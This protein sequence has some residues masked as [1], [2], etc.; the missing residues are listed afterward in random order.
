MLKIHPSE[1]YGQALVTENATATLSSVEATDNTIQHILESSLTEPPALGDGCNNV[2]PSFPNDDLPQS[3]EASSQGGVIV[4]LPEEETA[5]L[6]ASPEAQFDLVLDLAARGWRLHPIQA[7]GKAPLLSGWPSKASAEKETIQSWVAKYPHCNW[8][9]A[10][11]A[12]SNVFVLDVDNKGGKKG[13]ESLAALEEQYG[14]LP[15]T[16]VSLTGSGS[17]KQYFFRYPPNA[18]YLK[19]LNT[20]A[21][22]DGLD[23]KVEGGYVVIPPSV[24]TVPYKFSNS[25]DTPLAP[26]PEWLL[27]MLKSL[28]HK[29]YALPAT[30]A[31]S[32]K[33]QLIPVGSRHKYLVSVAGAMLRKGVSFAE[34]LAAMNAANKDRFATPYPDVEIEKKAKDFHARWHAQSTLEGEPSQPKRRLELIPLSQI[35]EKEI[36]WLWKP[37]LAY[38]MLAILSGNPSTGKSFVTLDI[39]A[40][41]TNGHEPFTHKPLPAVPVLYLSVENDPELVVRKRFAGL[42]GNPDLFITVPHVITGE[43]DEATRDSVQLSDIEPLDAALEQTKAKLVI[44]DPLQSYLGAKVDAHRANETRAILDPLIRLAK[45]HECCILIVRHL[46][47]IKPAVVQVESHPYLPETELLEFCKRKG[48][49]FLAFAPLG[50][51]MKPGLLGDPVIS[52]IAARVGKPRY[53]SCWHGRCNAARLYLPRLKRRPGRRKIS[54]SLLFLKTRLTKSIA[55]RPDSG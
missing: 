15:P 10:C 13:S 52:A 25:E 8:A 6:C 53:R 11:G 4:S 2:A 29:A 26:V 54:T 45:K 34:L 32:S 49:V 44:I 39:A 22:G 7:G 47:R 48:I 38:G 21:I 30:G 28:Q 55:F 14:T 41:L 31:S 9:V 18:G 17:G 27:E 1:K 43:G 50:H 40:A 51:G 23:I 20:G 46:K 33:E 3:P 5:S 16:L 35:E 19:N 36:R 24:T 42:K 37:Y 12:G